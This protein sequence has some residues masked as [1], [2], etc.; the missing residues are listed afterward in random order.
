MKAD[1]Y[2]GT[3]PYD[4]M[5]ESCRLYLE[6]IQKERSGRPVV[7]W[8]AGQCGIAAYDMLREEHVP[9][10]AFADRAYQQKTEYLGLPVWNPDSLE[11][12]DFYVAAAITSN[13]LSI[14][15]FL[16]DRGFGEQDFTHILNN[17]QQIHEDL[18]Y[19]GVPVGRCTYGY[20]ELLWDFPMASRIGRYCSINP[21]A[22]IFNNHPLEYVTT[23]PILDHRSCCTYSQ[24]LKRQKLCQKY[25][26]HTDNHPYEDSP[27]RNNRPVEIG[28]DVWIGGYVAIMPGV[29]IGDGAILAAGAVITHDVPPYAIV[30]GIPAR[31][32]RKRFSDDVIAK[33]LEIAWWEWEPEKI[34]ANIE[35]FYQ[36]EK[37]VEKFAGQAG[38]D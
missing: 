34:E 36:P 25:G 14:E 22:R 5:K 33:M 3:V 6:K 32:I 9:V 15:Q 26:N 8:G 24:Y 7:I 19:K 2:R 35:Y 4:N 31:I 1:L 17:F 29:R 13:S 10:K 30:G 23:S 11:P 16:L 27:L 20:K 12:D 38:K 37:F 21:T 18:V 28:N